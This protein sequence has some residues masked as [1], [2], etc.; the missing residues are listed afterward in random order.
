[1]EPHW[2]AFIILLVAIL[3]GST[4][5]VADLLDEHGLKWFRFAPLLFGILWGVFGGL[6]IIMGTKEFANAI[7]A[8]NI[9]FIFRMRIDYKNH[10]VAVTI[11]LIT[12]LAFGEVDLFVFFLFFLIFIFFGSVKDHL[13]ENP[14]RTN[15]L[16]L[17][18][19]F[20]WYYVLPPFIYALWSGH[21]NVF[22]GLLAYILSYNAVRY[23]ASK[24]GE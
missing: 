12:F 19:E 10:A 17:I 7:L 1:M 11:I 14:D 6:L 15:W 20:G 5:K 24:G 22:T 3:Y 9:A 4:M 23:A 2:P 16:Y 8:M 18:S 13:G 21:W